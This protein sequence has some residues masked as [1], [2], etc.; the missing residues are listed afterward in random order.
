MPRSFLLMLFPFAIAVLPTL[1]GVQQAQVKRIPP[2]GKAIPAEERKALTEDKDNL[3][4]EIEQLKSKLKGK[5]LDL[6]PDV[7]I[8]YTA[9]H[10]A[11]VYD[12]FFNIKETITAHKILKEGHERV[13]ALKSGQ[14]PWTTATGLVVRGYVSRIDA[15][16]QPY[17][18][19]VPA[20][21]KAGAD[22]RHRLDLWYHGRGETLNEISFLNG[23]QTSPGDFTPPDTIVLHLYGRYCNANHFAGEIDT[24]EA[25]DN[26]KKNYPIDVNRILVRGFS[27][28]GASTWNFAV[29]YTDLWAA[30][31]PGAGFSESPKFLKLQVDKLPDY[32]RKLL[33]LYD[34][35]DWAANLSQLPVVAYSGEIDGQKQAADIMEKAMDKEGLKLTHIIGPKTGHAYEKNAK[36]EIN[37]LVDAYAA[38]GRDPLPKKIRFVTYTLRYPKMFWVYVDGMGR[39]WEEAR[40]EAEIVNDDTVKVATKNV[41]ALTLNMPAGLCPLDLKRTPQVQ[42]DGQALKATPVHGDRSWVSHFR[43]GADGW[44]LV[45]TADD[46]T[47]RKQP[48]L[49]GPMDDAFMERFLMVRPTGKAYHEKVAEWT[50]TEMAHAIE[51]WR[52]QF[53]GEALQKNDVDV[54]DSD[55]ASSNLVLWG[56]PGSN[57]LLA[58]IMDLGKLPLTWNS[59]KI[60]FAGKEYASDHHSIAIIFPNP[61][62]PKKYLV[63]NSGFTFREFDYLN[64]ARQ[65]PKLADY[66][67]LDVSIPADARHPAGIVSGGFFN[68]RWEVT[69]E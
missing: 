60:Q 12:E 38:Q 18:L 66:A 48:F 67:M 2:A 9:V 51:H 44:S 33:H 22:H 59:A 42:I 8:F 7:Q 35:I 15:S 55:I 19:V 40:V 62:N 43:K 39:H 10:Y 11:L 1:A 68:E 30:A 64:N 53:R 17:G 36:V 24:L 49:Q 3:G 26:V 34:C 56:D 65:I 63:L 16:V 46:G 27:M 45:P 6:I 28:G 29:H 32:E 4:K 14:A 47:L 13:S 61:L 54:I 57:R 69:K 37:R 41:A 20:T 31:A 58:R 23:R 50:S 52:R 5:L 21:F 25:M